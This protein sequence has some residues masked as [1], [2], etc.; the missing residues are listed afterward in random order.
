MELIA[1]RDGR[2]QRVQV[3]RLDEGYEVR[4]GERVYQVD[5]RV[6]DGGVQSLLIAHGQYEVSIHERGEGRYWVSGTDGACLVEVTDRLTHLAQETRDGTGGGGL[7]QISALMPGRV[8]AILAKEGDRLAAGQGVVV[9]EAMKMENE[10]QV[11][12]PA[13]VRRI[14]VE[15]GKTVEGGDPLFEIE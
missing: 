1:Q 15:V 4:V 10:I 6:T 7:Q 9:V 3:R 2:P 14:L 13:V 11:E 12:R 5:A 8:V